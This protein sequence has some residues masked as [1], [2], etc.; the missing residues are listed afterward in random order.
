MTIHHVR[1]VHGSAAQT[2]P[3]A[4]R[5]LLLHEYTAADAWPLV[6]C[7]ELRGVSTAAW[8]WVSPP[9]SRRVGARAR[10]ACRWPAADHQGS[11]YEKPARERAAG[12]SK[13]TRSVFVPARI[14]ALVLAFHSGKSTGP[15]VR[16]A[17]DRPPTTA[18]IDFA[19]G[20]SK[21][22][23]TTGSFKNWQGAGECRRRPRRP[24]APS[25]S[26]VNTDSIQ[27]LDTQQTAMLKDSDFFD[28]EKF[29]KMTFESK[30]IERNRRERLQGRGRHHAARH[31][32]GPMTLDVTVADRRPRCAG[33]GSLRPLTAASAPSS[34][35]NS[36]WTKYVDMVGDTVGDHHRHRPRGAEIAPPGRARWPSRAI[37]P[38]PR[39]CI[40]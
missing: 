32:R 26:V 10:A 38:P 23:R 18:T 9:S 36:A 21:I 33:R 30:K 15:G 37:I 27:M 16:E 19:I 40:G 6:G 8:C 35:P 29:P 12:S 28:V 1:L 4:Q 14:F 39:R 13:P 7:G 25:R 17:L 11:I 3:T 2:I 34:A 24:G 20:D 31:S 5:R 22:F